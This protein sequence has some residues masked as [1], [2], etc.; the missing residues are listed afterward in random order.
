MAEIA[1]SSFNLDAARDIADRLDRLASM[2]PMDVDNLALTVG[3]AQPSLEAAYVRVRA[4]LRQ[5][6]ADEARDELGYAARKFADAP[7][8]AELR[9]AVAAA[10]Y[11]ASALEK[12][13]ADFRARFGDS[14]AAEA[15][16]GETFSDLRQYEMG[17]EHLK[18]AIALAPYW[19]TPQADLGLLLVQAAR[20]DEAIKVLE[21]AT[22]LDPFNVRAGNSL[23]LVKEVASYERV[24]TPH[25]IVRAKPGLDAL[26]AAEIAAVMEENHAAVTGSQPGALAYEPPQKTFIDLMPDHAWFAVRVTGLSKIHTI[27]ASTGPVIAME[28]PREGKG[29]TGAY[30]WPRV[31]RHEYTHTVGLS[32]TN[33]RLPHWFTEAQAQYLERVPREYSTAKLLYEAYSSDELFDFTSINIAFTRP[34]KPTDRQLAYAQGQWMYEYMVERFGARAPLTLMDLF[35]KGVR[36]EEAVQQSFHISREQFLT[37][38]KAWANKQLVAWGMLPQPGAVTIESLIKDLPKAEGSDEQPTPTP[39]QIASWAKAHPDNADIVRL[40]VQQVI[41]EKGGATLK[42]VEWFDRYATLR[43]VDPLPHQ[44]LAKLYL[45]DDKPELAIPQLEWLDARTDRLAVYATQLAGLYARQQN[46]EQASAKAERLRASPPT[47]PR[48]ASWRRRSPYS[49]RTSRPHDGT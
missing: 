39:E 21:G 43:P 22:K 31:L 13:L 49:A 18:K 37:D 32:R 17:A 15:R 38:F 5:N 4:A 44:Q 47:T 46:W 11:D 35:A 1:V 14:P 28:A 42:D 30:D 20:D 6:E 41:E 2:Q 3:N 36:E 16:V 24:E 45:S 34:K 8:V 33:N 26:L 27:A 9:C 48:H 19:P 7:M 12:A 10:S 23:R 29:H 25:F 40:A